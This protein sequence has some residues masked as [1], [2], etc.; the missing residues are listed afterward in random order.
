MY[1]LTLVVV[2]ALFGIQTAAA[3]STIVSSNASLKNGD[4]QIKSVELENTH[5][6]SFSD[7]RDVPRDVQ[8]RCDLDSA[9]QGVI[10]RVTV[11]GLADFDAGKKVVLRDDKGRKF[12]SRCWSGIRSEAADSKGVNEHGSFFL[13]VGPDDSAVVTVSFGP[14]SVDIRMKK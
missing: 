14:A 11:M 12:T 2:L 8:K 3:Q 10:W 1:Q 6:R 9:T 5:S 4:Q 7:P 13:A